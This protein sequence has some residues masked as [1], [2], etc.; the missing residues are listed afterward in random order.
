MG[1]GG[2]DG[3]GC[4]MSVYNVMSNDACRK[5]FAMPTVTVIT[6]LDGVSFVVITETLGYSVSTVT[7]S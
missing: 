2:L 3:C 4:Y 1:S 7:L 6:V 5:A